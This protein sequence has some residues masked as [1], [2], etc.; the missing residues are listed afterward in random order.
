LETW[1]PWGERFIYSWS[2][3]TI[4]RDLSWRLLNLIL[5]PSLPFLVSISV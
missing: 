2:T 1:D 3:C 4:E 5:P